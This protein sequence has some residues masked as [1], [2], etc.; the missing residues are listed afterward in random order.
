VLLTVEKLYVM[1]MRTVP[2]TSTR[3]ATINSFPAQGDDLPPH[4]EAALAAHTSTSKADLD[5]WHRRLN[6]L[7]VDAV[8]RMSKKG[9]VRAWKLQGGAHLPYP[10]NPASK[11]CRHAPRSTSRRTH[12]PTLCSAV[13]TQD[14]C[15]KLPT[16]SREGFEILRDVIDDK[17]RKVFMT[18]MRLKSEVPKHLE[19]LITHVEVETGSRVQV[20]RSN[21]GGEYAGKVAKHY[22]EGKGIEHEMM[23]AHTP[24]HND[25]AECMNW[26]LLD[27]VHSTLTNADL[28]Q[29][30][31]FDTLEYAVTIHNATP[32][33]TLNDMMP[34]EAWGRDERNV[35]SFCI[36][37]CKTFV[38]VLEKHCLKFAAQSLIC[39]FLGYV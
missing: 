5:T 20:L 2:L 10:V 15:G 36:F 3:I 28:P 1:D 14:V 21:G 29:S 18:G 34:E 35:S 19:N 16:R 9:M 13:S 37:R 38:H 31:W 32:M 27:K 33:H 39:T 25:V 30:F 22:L 12:V 6:H 17:S 26:T 23:T 4:A 11:A 24:Q 8:L 7:N